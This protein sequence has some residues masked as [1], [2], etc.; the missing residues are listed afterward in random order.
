[1]NDTKKKLIGQY[2]GFLTV[3]SGLHQIIRLGGTYKVNQKFG[4]YRWHI[5]DPIRFEKDLKV[6]IHDLGWRSGGGFLPQMSNISSI[7]FC[8]LKG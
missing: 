1:M 6:E 3:Y 7:A 2:N 4:M 5:T 8:F